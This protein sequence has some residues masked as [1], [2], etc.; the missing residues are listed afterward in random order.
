MFLNKFL[1]NEVCSHLTI[2]VDLQLGF[3]SF[4]AQFWLPFLPLINSFSL[5]FIHV[6]ISLQFFFR[7][8]TLKKKKKKRRRKFSANVTIK[9]IINATLFINHIKMS[10]NYYI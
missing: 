6:Y 7:C 3:L 10:I 8:S 5:I 2:R 1:G 9:S 4:Q